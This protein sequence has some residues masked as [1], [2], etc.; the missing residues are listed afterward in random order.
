[1]ALTKADDREV[2]SNQIGQVNILIR[3]RIVFE[4]FPILEF[5]TTLR[6]IFFWSQF[7]FSLNQR[8]GVCSWITFRN[9]CFFF[10]RIFLVN[11]NLA[12]GWTVIFAVVKYYITISQCVKKSSFQ[13]VQCCKNF[14]LIR[15]CRLSF[16][17]W[18]IL[19]TDLKCH[20][21]NWII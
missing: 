13:S 15:Y 12:I 2:I 1:M 8:Q 3:L 7:Y 4:L 9:K 11:V 10:H 14:L 16:W 5:C 19:Y 18:N 17:Y 6:Q 21:E 20:Y